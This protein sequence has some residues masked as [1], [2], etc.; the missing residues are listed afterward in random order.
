MKQKM[1]ISLMIDRYTRNTQC[2]CINF[3]Q[4]LYSSKNES[5][6]GCN[7]PDQSAIP[8]ITV[9]EVEVAIKEI[10]DNKATKLYNQIMEERGYQCVG[11]KKNHTP[12]QKR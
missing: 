6:P 1:A 2:I 10:K 5:K 7:S 4:E 12:T 8:K 3:Y 9:R 11:W